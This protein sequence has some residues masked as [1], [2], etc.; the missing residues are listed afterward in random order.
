[1]FYLKSLLSNHTNRLNVTCQLAVI[2]KWPN[3][4]K[5]FTT[6][7]YDFAY[8]RHFSIFQHSLLKVVVHWLAYKYV[9]HLI[10]RRYRTILL[11]LQKKK[12]DI[13]QNILHQFCTKKIMDMSDMFVACGKRVSTLNVHIVWIILASKNFWLSL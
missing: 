13:L 12:N 5:L 7:F 8:V 6:N 11:S 1:M 3:Y 9:N 2:S 10:R 4:W